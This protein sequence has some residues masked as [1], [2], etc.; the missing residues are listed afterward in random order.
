MRGMKRFKS[1]AMI[2]SVLVMCSTMAYSQS[3]EVKPA[4]KADAQAQKMAEA[5]DRMKSSMSNGGSEGIA[6]AGDGL[7]TAMGGF[8]RDGGDNSSAVRA[9][10]SKAPR[11]ATLANYKGPERDCWEVCVSWGPLHVC[12]TWETRCR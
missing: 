1:V 3:A 11:K 9:P 10:M 2:V 8:A 5:F 12:Y 6:G 4:A 7:F